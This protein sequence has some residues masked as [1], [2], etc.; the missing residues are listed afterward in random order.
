MKINAQHNVLEKA[1]N[2]LY[3]R[4]VRIPR[5]MENDIKKVF[6]ELDVY[7]RKSIDE[8]LKQQQSS[9]CDADLRVFEDFPQVGVGKC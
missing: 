9:D 4:N 8:T 3:D 2:F 1:V 7:D 6:E 5:E